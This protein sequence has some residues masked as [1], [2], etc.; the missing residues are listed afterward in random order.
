ME[1]SEKPLLFP[2]KA[3]DQCQAIGKDAAS[4]ETKGTPVTLLWW[5]EEGVPH[6]SSTLHKGRNLTE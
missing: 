5:L 2:D 1:T 4:S 3:G 6:L